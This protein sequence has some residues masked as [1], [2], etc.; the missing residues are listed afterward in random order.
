[1]AFDDLTDEQIELLTR[2]MGYIESGKHENVFDVSKDNRGLTILTTG[3]EGHSGEQLKEVYDPLL[4]LGLEEYN[5]LT[6]NR[7]G[8]NI[9]S[10]SLTKK[11]IDEFSILRSGDFNSI[12]Q[13]EALGISPEMEQLVWEEN[14]FKLFISHTHHHKEA[15]GA[16]KEALSFY[17][18]SAFVAHDNID[19]EEDWR[20]IMVFALRTTDAAVAFL[21]DHFHPSD[22]TD[23]EIGWIL[24]RNK[25]VIKLDLG[26]TPYGFMG[27]RQ[28]LNGKRKTEEQIAKEI[29]DILMKNELSKERVAEVIELSKPRLINPGF[30]E[31][32]IGWVEHEESFKHQN[33]SED[34]VTYRHSGDY[35][36]KLFLRVGGTKIFQ[37]VNAKLPI[38]TSISASVWAY[39]P[40]AGSDSTKYFTLILKTIDIEG[41]EIEVPVHEYGPLEEWKKIETELVITE[42]RIVEL[43]I[44]AM[45]TWGGG[46]YK[47]RDKAVW[48]DD[49]DLVITYPN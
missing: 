14:Q 46:D 33:K 37:K 15:A 5:F 18:I 1:M 3:K 17:H 6:I 8:Q 31:G 38:G 47:K 29:Y 44:Q 22:W 21:T 42:S 41:N 20:D 19:P 13:A 28:A 2:L 11:A 25:P 40:E 4:F 48:V 16:L 49:F 36:R 9:K 27:N 45:T 10:F 23:Q 12:Q 43:E 32:D 34:D 26:K 30:D 7:E 35:S 24:G 39:M